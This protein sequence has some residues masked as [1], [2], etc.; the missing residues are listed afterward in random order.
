MKSFEECI[1]PFQMRHYQGDLF[2]KW[3]I[4]L[5]HRSMFDTDDAEYLFGTREVSI[6]DVLY[7]LSEPSDTYYLI[8]RENEIAFLSWFRPVEGTA[9]KCA[10]LSVWTQRG[11]RASKI[12]M[13][14]LSKI[15]ELAFDQY[16]TVIGLTTQEKIVKFGKVWGNYTTVGNIPNIFNGLEGCIRFVTKKAFYKSACYEKVQEFRGV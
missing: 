16:S 13:H 12:N 9:N 4:T 5:W 1:A 6:D 7:T 8:N 15:H 11:W 2:D 3:L 14:F 10:C